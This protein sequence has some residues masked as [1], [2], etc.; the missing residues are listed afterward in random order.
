MVV[1]MSEREVGGGAGGGITVAAATA[2]ASAATDDIVRQ[3]GAPRAIKGLTSLTV[4]QRQ[5]GSGVRTGCSGRGVVQIK[6][7]AHT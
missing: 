5:S 7:L 2:A 4:T 1:V 3:Q 6:S